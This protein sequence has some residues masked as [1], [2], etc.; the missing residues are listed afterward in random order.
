MGRSS[1]SSNALEWCTSSKLR[2]TRLKSEG[3]KEAIDL[4]EAA[5][6]DMCSCDLVSDC[7]QGTCPVSAVHLSEQGRSEDTVL[8]LN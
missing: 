6:G 4:A 7:R 5:S 2:S 1:R 8:K 3:M